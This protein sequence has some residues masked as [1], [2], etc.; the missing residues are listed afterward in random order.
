MCQVPSLIISSTHQSAFS[1]AAKMFTT[2]VQTPVRRCRMSSHR[3]MW[4]TSHSASSGA[5]RIFDSFEGDYEYDDPGF[6]RPRTPLSRE[7]AGASLGNVAVSRKRSYHFRHA[8][9]LRYPEFRAAYRN[10]PKSTS[11]ETENWS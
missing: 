8:A 4:L 2:V 9:Q 3:A 5:T 10:V 7:P 6:H 1:L 11:E